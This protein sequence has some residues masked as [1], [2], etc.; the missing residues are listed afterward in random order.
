[1]KV[2]QV[3]SDSIHLMHFCKAIINH[4]GPFVFLSETAVEMPGASAKY[5]IPFRGMNPVSWLKNAAKVKSMLRSEKP[6]LIHIHQINRL[7]WVIALIAKQLKIP[8]I[9]TAWGSDVLLIPKK[10]RIFKSITKSVLKNSRIVTA[11]S[12]DMIHAMS[13]IEAGDTHYVHLQYGIDAIEPGVKKNIV[14]SNRLHKPLYR[15]DLIIRLFAEFQKSTS[16]WKLVIGA[17]GEET[18]ALKKLA[19]ELLIPDSYEFIGWVDSETNAKYYSESKLYVSLPHSDG[20]SVSLLEA[21]SANCIPVVSDLAVSHEWIENTG[22]GIIYDGIS[23]P[24]EQAL[25]LNTEKCFQINQE[26]IRQHALRKTTVLKFF[27][28]YQSL[29]N[30][31]V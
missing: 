22:N 2:L 6:E 13:E 23:N 1:M 18:E 12:M 25:E 15:I 8:V 29:L 19:L 21:M 27:H 3:G 16:S 9:A 11:D 30:K 24:F 4:T 31:K 17:T 28:L 26:K 14:Y 7:A 10:N 20:T 5:V